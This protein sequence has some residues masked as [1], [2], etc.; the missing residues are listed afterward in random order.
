[1][2]RQSHHIYPKDAL[3][4]AWEE[5]CAP[6]IPQALAHHFE[7]CES[8][9]EV[10]FLCAYLEVLEHKRIDGGA[11]DW[12]ICETLEG[13]DKS[14][15]I[16][17]MY[18]GLEFADVIVLQPKVSGYRPDFVLWR[19]L[20]PALST[21][22]VI[23]ECDGFDFHDRTKALA[24]RDKQRDRQLQKTGLQILRFTG[25][26]LWKNARTCAIEVFDFL[27]EAVERV[28]GTNSERS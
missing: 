18:E 13:A 14:H 11:L 3:T 6:E 27:S 17:E 28:Q 5:W 24:A 20:P 22:R 25:S 4:R 12:I 16:F 10:A 23:V 21:P 7:K 9:I 1:M 2:A 15:A 19:I 26:E 8:K